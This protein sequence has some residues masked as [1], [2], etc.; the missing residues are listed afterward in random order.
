M[1]TTIKKYRQ[2]DVYIQETEKIP[3]AVKEVS[4]A[5]LAYGEATG[6]RHVVLPDTEET[7]IVYGENGDGKFL[8]I[9]GGTATVRHEEHAPVTLPPGKY[10]V[11]I[12][13]EYD[14]EA[15]RRERKVTD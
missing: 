3:C 11:H 7:L 8:E 15:Y 9:S 2:G 1:P 4:E 6:H 13:R 10:F 5:V 14:P 12:Q